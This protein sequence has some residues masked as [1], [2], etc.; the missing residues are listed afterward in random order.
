LLDKDLDFSK[1]LISDYKISKRSLTP[2]EYVCKAFRKESKERKG[3]D[4]YQSSPAVQEL[5][6][7]LIDKRQISVK[8]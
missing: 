4:N 5:Y 3:K 1:A 6:S 8:T 2:I 7:S